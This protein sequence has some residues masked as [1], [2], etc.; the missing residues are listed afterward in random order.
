MSNS[1]LDVYKHHHKQI[2]LA[3]IA[4]WLHDMGKCTDE[5]IVN[6]ASDKPADFKYAYKTAYLD[7]LDSSMTVSVLGEAV[8][9]HDLIS[10][11]LPRNVTDA[12]KPWLVRALG[13]CHAAAHIDKEEAEK[14]GKQLKGDTRRSTAFGYEGSVVRDLTLQLKGLPLNPLASRSDLLRQLQDVFGQA[15]G[16]T[17]RSENEVTLWDWSSVVA[18]FFK[19]AVAGALLGHKPEPRELR[20]RFLNIRVKRLAFLES[21]ARIPDLLARHAILDN[22]LERVRILLEEKLAVATR[23]YAGLNDHIYIV[24]DV[25]HLLDLKDSTGITLRQ[26]IEEEFAK[27]TVKGNLQLA[28]NGEIVPLIELDG[29]TWWGQSPDRNP[30]KDEVPPI[31]RILATEFETSPNPK[32]VVSWWQKPGMEVCPVCRLRPM[33]EDEETCEYCLKRR[34]SRIDTWQVNPAQTIWMDEIADRNGR[35]ALIVGKF[36]L[37][38]WL[39]GDLVQTMLVKAAEGEPGR[40]VP[41]NPSP[42]RLRRVWETT[43]RFWTESVEELLK[44]IPD[45]RRW[46]LVSQV[47]LGAN[48]PPEVTVCDGTLNG[49]PIS[50][51]RIGD[52]LVT[53]SFVEEPKPGVLSISWEEGRC[54]KQATISIAEVKLAQG[55]LS[56]YC[57]YAPYLRLLASP[58]QFLALVP[59]G[60]ALHITEKIHEEYCKQFSKVRNRLPLFLGLVFFHRK[61]P[62]TA[63]IDTARRMLDTVPLGEEGGWKVVGSEECGTGVTPEFLK[64]SKHFDKWRKL[65]LE[66]GGQRVEWAVSTVMGDGTTSDEWYPYFFVEVDPGPRRLRFQLRGEGETD[67]QKVGRVSKKVYADR[68]LVHVNDLREGDQVAVSPSRFAYVYLDHTARRF[69][70]D[71][72]KDVFLLDELP[73]LV[74][75]WED[76]CNTPDMTDTKLHSLWALLEGKWALWRLGEACSPDCQDRLE[77]FRQ[78]SEAALRR[79]RLLWDGKRGVSVDDVVAG[80]FRRCL[81][82]HMEILKLRV[83]EGKSGRQLS[84]TAV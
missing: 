51:L 67:P 1:E 28:I 48:V 34:D 72:E 32:V 57:S 82:L 60:D 23:I 56:K 53:V 13:R 61:M 15:L 71:P 59:A 20:W 17:R 75:M 69:E 64:E 55:G 83:K 41:K 74:R 3:E 54:R 52:Q 29:G 27:G 84:K 21:A 50:V 68:W 24:P 70:Y 80:R 45:R 11:G 19:A 2:L 47:P 6:Q 78:L 37:E 14:S 46:E 22:A 42:A 44:T 65:S 39:S 58:D 63:V 76:I 9:V 26:L 40:C 18:A 77:A 81:E 38:N 10:Q 16:D 35:V 79:D 62:L 36:G 8:L 30:D 25:P 43:R 66:K 73:R 4:G 49:K 31:S 5:H 33:K 7:L 12:S